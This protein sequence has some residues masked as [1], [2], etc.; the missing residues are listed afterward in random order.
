MGQEYAS[1]V[2]I[3]N[4]PGS[5]ETSVTSVRQGSQA[6]TGLPS[7]AANKNGVTPKTF[8]A[9]LFTVPKFNYGKDF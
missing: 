5:T 8:V 6:K 7:L 1:Q 4:I 2:F 9:K 3:G